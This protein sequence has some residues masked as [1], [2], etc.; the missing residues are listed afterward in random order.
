MLETP[1]NKAFVQAG[2]GQWY[3]QIAPLTRSSVR[4][5]SQPAHD[6]EIA[7]GQSKFGGE[8]DLPDGYVWQ[9]YKNRPLAFLAQFHLAEVS[10]YDQSG[11]LPKVG[12]LSFFYD[13]NQEPWG[14]DPQ[15]KGGWQVLYLPENSKVQRTGAPQCQDCL[16]KPIARPCK[17]E[18][19]TEQNLPS[20]EAPQILELGLSENE[21]SRYYEL[22]NSGVI[23]RLLGHP[24]TIQGEAMDVQAQL[25]S[26]G[27]YLDEKVDYQ[28]PEIRALTAEAGEWL[29]LFQL[30]SDPN[31][32][33]YW[34]MSGRLYFW[35]RKADLQAC[36]FSRV[37][38]IG[39]C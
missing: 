2:L 15:D 4:I 7:L 5:I 10:P 35:I 38:L 21:R 31:T 8:P 6:N 13:P 24:A 1:E 16:F 23:H 11:L 22:S 30:D 14:F 19:K 29:L 32:D 12:L 37:W 20:W 33:F 28:A 34:G 36:D 3:N 17:L 25:V 18:F 9:Y 39:Q 26:N 27:I